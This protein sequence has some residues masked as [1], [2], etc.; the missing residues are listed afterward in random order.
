MA[1]AD[2]EAGAR[3]ELGAARIVNATG[4]SGPDQEMQDGQQEQQERGGGGGGTA[5]RVEDGLSLVKLALKDRRGA[6]VAQRQRFR[7]LEK[8]VDRLRS[9]LAGLRPA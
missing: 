3:R 7:K 2:T 4:I 6:A 5:S 8:Q 1:E 9:E